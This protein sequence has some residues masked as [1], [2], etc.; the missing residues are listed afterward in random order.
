MVQQYGWRRL[1]EVSPDILFLIFATIGGLA[2]VAL[3]PPM[4]GGNELFNFQRVAG[5]AAF[6]PLIEPAQ[7]PLGTMRL[8]RAAHAQFNP[9][10][11]PPYHYSSVQF[12]ALASIPLDA[13]TPATLEPNPIA[14]LNPVSYIPQVAA[15]WLG[16]A[17]GWSPLALFYL[18]RLS[19]LAAA[20]GLT[21][22]AIRRMP[23]HQYGLCALALLPTIAFSRSTLDADQVTN[24]LSFLFVASILSV[25]TQAERISLRTVLF[26]AVI[27]FLTA[28]CKSAYFVLLPLAFAVPVDRYGSTWRW[29]FA[30]LAITIPGIVASLGWM[31]ALKH[32]YFAGIHYY[33]LDSAVF[34]DRQ[35]ERILADPLGFAAVVARTIFMSSLL[36][37]TLLG[38][39]GIFGPP[40]L[41][42]IVA[43]LLVLGAFAAALAAEGASQLTNPSRLL[44][45][46]AIGVF[47]AG[48]GLTLTLVYIQWN[49][50]GAPV[51]SGFNGRYLYPLA[52]PLL[53]FLPSKKSIV[54]GLDAPAWLAILGLV[55][56]CSTLGVTWTTYWA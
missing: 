10:Q 47:L 32:T 13:D 28:Q 39:L 33:V 55:A 42:P 56:A 36:P 6:H 7:I 34:P 8:L 26:L 40:V 48:F 30:S 15:Y 22:F 50:V 49:G 29:L 25:A 9:T 53:M 43:Y 17:F 24:G 31:I 23:F 51:I 3:I 44:R 4:A 46:L 14:V 11:M 38:I 37:M 45:W 2:L 1:I 52:P 5:V 27:A 21:F 54:L 35:I 41:M 20:I 16:E 19:G 12:D 18:G